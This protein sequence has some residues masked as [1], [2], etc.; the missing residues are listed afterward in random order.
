M[1]LE[2]GS[3]NY[4]LQQ[5]YFIRRMIIQSDQIDFLQS[6]KSDFWLTFRSRIS[7]CKSFKEPLIVFWASINSINEINSANRTVEMPKE[8]LCQDHAWL[9]TPANESK[10]EI[11]TDGI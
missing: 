11:I 4:T 1:K 6:I 2:L 5:S 8:T 7:D 10:N 9:A 3:T